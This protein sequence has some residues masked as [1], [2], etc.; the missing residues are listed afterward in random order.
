MYSVTVTDK[1][2]LNNDTNKQSDVGGGL[3]ALA[4]QMEELVGTELQAERL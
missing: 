1:H 2:H 3:L 4:L